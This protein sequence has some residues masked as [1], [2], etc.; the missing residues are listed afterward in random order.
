MSAATGP[1]PAGEASAHP[2]S[3]DGPHR[4]AELV[5]R[6]N[7]AT[8]SLVASL[9]DDRANLSL[10]Q[11]HLASYA[12]LRPGTHAAPAPA[13]TPG[14]SAAGAAEAA[15]I[16]C[17]DP[18]CARMRVRAAG[19]RAP[20]NIGGVPF[21]LA[22][23]RIGMICAMKA[24]A[25]SLI[26]LADRHPHL[27]L[28]GET[29]VES[30]FAAVLTTCLVMI[31]AQHAGSASAR[32]PA[33]ASPPGSTRP[34]RDDPARLAILAEYLRGHWPT[35]ENKRAL[36]A[37]MVSPALRRDTWEH[38][39]HTQNEDYRGVL[40]VLTA[41]MGP[42]V[43]AGQTERVLAA[44][45][46]GVALP[47]AVTVADVLGAVPALRVGEESA[48]HGQW[49][50]CV[51]EWFASLRALQPA[52]AP[53]TSTA[54][55]NLQ[56][57]YGAGNEQA[58]IPIHGDGITNLQWPPTV[59]V[60]SPASNVAEDKNELLPLYG[61]IGELIGAV[62]HAGEKSHARM[63]GVCILSHA[64]GEAV[65]NGLQRGLRLPPAVAG[66][67][68]S[69]AA[70]APFKRAW[71]LGTVRAD[72]PNSYGPLAAL[73]QTVHGKAD[74]AIPAIAGVI[75]R[76]TLSE[77]QPFHPKALYEQIAVFHPWDG[78]VSLAVEAQRRELFFAPESRRT[79]RK[80]RG[81]P[82]E[83]EEEEPE[84]PPVPA[85]HDAD[86]GGDDAEADEK[87]SKP[88]E[89]TRKITFNQLFLSQIPGVSEE[90]IRERAEEL[91]L[92]TSRAVFRGSLLARIT[93]TELLE[94]GQDLPDNL[95]SD[96]FWHQVRARLRDAPPLRRHY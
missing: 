80:A 32:A 33:S 69:A 49:K 63:P 34:G 13:S 67:Q 37:S 79:R 9:L 3:G 86:E 25:L 87:P 93:L 90:T 62:L 59:P 77:R 7:A 56:V 68:D 29:E 94:S 83:P 65:A 48:E 95:L 61:A 35:I 92:Y 54:H 26:K 20:D 70:A 46:A 53:T 36:A 57:P 75:E 1:T 22:G 58:T 5:T 12:C 88:M 21:A 47:H 19:L 18:Q 50:Q 73:L 74:G 6:R 64:Y 10:V 71:H 82:A 78:A 39:R 30:A 17:P 42:S 11:E 43:C 27:A 66:A 15:R 76:L 8:D 38:L 81:A 89:V 91:A 60:V 44:T 24:A 41:T 28:T 85:T 31:E 45:E 16:A 40:A 23:V 96:T 55:V 51:H 52:A 4:E 14:S 72:K 84:A 2:T